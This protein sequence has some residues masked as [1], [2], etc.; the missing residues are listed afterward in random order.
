MLFW[1]EWETVTNEMVAKINAG[2][3]DGAKTAFDGKKESLKTKWD[4]IKGAR[5]FQVS[6]ETQK[7]MQESATKNTT[8]LTSAMITNSMKLAADKAKA[9]KL[10][11]LVTEYGEIF[12]M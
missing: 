6:A 10:K 4:G 12:K 7:K 2:D 11:A 9:D 1:T 3:I 5:G 8:A